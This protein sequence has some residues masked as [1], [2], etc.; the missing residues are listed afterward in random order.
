MKTLL[1]TT[2]LF[3]V[4]RLALMA[5]AVKV[6]L[7]IVAEYRFY[8]PAD[9]SATFLIGREDVFVGL[10]PIAFYAHILAGPVTLLLAG[11]LMIAGKTS[12]SR[13]LLHRR[14]GRVQGVLVIGVLV[15]SGLVMA[16]D[17]HTGPA[18][19]WGFG[20]HAVFT[21]ASMFAAIR[22]AIHGD[23]S[24]HQRW[25]TRCFLCLMAPVIL[26]ISM[27]ASIVF[28]FESDAYY[29]FNAWAS[30][31]VPLAIYESV[32]FIKNQSQDHHPFFKTE[33]MP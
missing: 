31:L 19:A 7:S 11:W 9:F 17:A 15:P 21:G 25:A 32:H 33:A 6:W 2:P 4:L 16:W 1:G 24:S 30:W 8:F 10:Y 29:Q 12:H 22:A 18:A 28:G 20:L 26:R 14:L 27:G 23:L 3:A 5:L 13:R